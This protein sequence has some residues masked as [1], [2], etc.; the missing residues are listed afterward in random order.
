MILLSPPVPNYSVCFSKNSHGGNYVNEREFI[1]F[2][3]LEKRDRSIL[4]KANLNI[5][6]FQCHLKLKNIN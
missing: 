5:L 3:S 6:N 4:S 1:V 2:V